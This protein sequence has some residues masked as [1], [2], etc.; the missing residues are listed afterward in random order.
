M[1]T[2]LYLPAYSVT[3][4]TALEKGTKRFNSDYTFRFYNKNENPCF[5]YPGL[6]VSAGHAFKKVTLAYDIG[7]DLQGG[8][9]LLGDSGG[10]QIATGQIDA[11]GDYLPSIFNWLE[12]NTTHAL[13][14][15]IPMYINKEG[16]NISLEDKI[17]ISN[18][19]FSYFEKN[20][21]GK[22]KYLNVIHG[23][24]QKDLDLWFNEVSSKYSF[25]G[26]WAIGSANIDIFY[27]L[28]SLFYLIKKNQLIKNET[29]KKLIHI[30]GISRSKDMIYL[31]YLQKKLNDNGYNYQ[32]TYDSSTPDISAGM[33][34]YVLFIDFNKILYITFSSSYKNVNK[35][36]I[37][38]CQCPVCSN[39]TLDNVYRED[40]SGFATAAYNHMSFHNLYKMLEYKKSLESLINFNDYAFYKNTFDDKTMFIFKI[41]DFL[42]EDINNYE[43]LLYKK[44]VIMTDRKL[45]YDIKLN[46]DKN[47]LF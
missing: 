31:E 15:D 8:G 40:K 36:N 45:K 4:L 11:K 33:G 43:M 12:N 37:L 35:S 17:K 26:G 7:F 6:L 5:Y 42:F 41:I 29:E 32:L 30:L 1:K 25:N 38:P 46:S 44:K 16:V 34:N 10:Y 27:I 23:R 14:I 13:N 24:N 39:I 3:G 9:I 20:Q 18:T 22:T 21:S 19:N 28:Q 47:S 2:A